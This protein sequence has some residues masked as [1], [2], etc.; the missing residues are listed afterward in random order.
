MRVL[1]RGFYI[2]TAHAKKENTE[3]VAHFCDP[4][5]EEAGLGA[6]S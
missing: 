5:T 3:Y 6:L 2:T 4:G 1:L